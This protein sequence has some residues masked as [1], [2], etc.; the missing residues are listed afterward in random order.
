[1]KKKTLIVLSLDFFWFFFS[2][3]QIP[4]ITV[5]QSQVICHIEA[6]PVVS[7]K[8]FLGRQLERSV[9]KIWSLHDI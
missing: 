8:K 9:D 4:E 5:K 3:N 1:M 7:T 6:L 2:Q